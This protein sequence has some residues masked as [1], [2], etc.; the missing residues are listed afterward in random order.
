M[1][2]LGLSLA[3]TLSYRVRREYLMMEIEKRGAGLGE[4][5]GT[6]SDR[7]GWLNLL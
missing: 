7:A 5:W 4:W 3:L 2:V 1:G 6:S